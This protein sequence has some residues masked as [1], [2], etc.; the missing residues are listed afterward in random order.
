MTQ[1][2][3]RK[4]TTQKPAATKGRNFRTFQL[5]SQ[6]E[7][8]EIGARIA[9]ARD[10]AGLTQEQVADLATFSKRSL[11]DYEAGVTVPY[12]Q[13]QELGRLL[14]REV[15]WFLHGETPADPD[16]LARLEAGIAAVTTILEHLEEGIARILE[17]L[18]AQAAQPNPG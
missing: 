6:L 16:R 13:M 3:R 14:N 11:Q 1:R 2:I 15:A 9:K 8:K 4:G 10:E 17:R 7:A 12:R 5:V 18:D